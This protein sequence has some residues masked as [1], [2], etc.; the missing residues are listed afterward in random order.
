MRNLNKRWRAALMAF[1]M[2]R[3]KDREVAEDLTQEVFVRMLRRDG[4]EGVAD[5]Y[6]FAI[7][8]NL[9]SDRARR[10]QVRHANQNVIEHM[11]SSD[12]DMRDPHRIAVG[13]ADLAAIVA[14]LSELPERQRT[15]FTLYRLE[16]MS[17][18]LIGEAFGISASAV[19]KQVAK[20]MTHLIARL[21]GEE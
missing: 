13:R 2:R 11:F 8:A 14:A 15:I 1:F 5:S 3:V 21:E 18:E 12:G 20:T 4:T 7:A 6:V 10:Q 9:L 16:N 19:K 17:Q